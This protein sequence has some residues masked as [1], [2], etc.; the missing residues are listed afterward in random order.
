MLRLPPFAI[1]S[2]LFIHTKNAL[3]LKRLTM[4]QCEVGFICCATAQLRLCLSR[5]ELFPDSILVLVQELKTNGFVVIDN[6]ISKETAAQVA[7]GRS[8]TLG[9]DAPPH[10]AQLSLGQGLGRR[11]VLHGC[12]KHWQATVIIKPLG[13]ALPCRHLPA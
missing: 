7:A 1:C 8:D 4:Q 6:F 10:L 12:M 11:R 9:R 5:S 13:P 3:Q 2:R